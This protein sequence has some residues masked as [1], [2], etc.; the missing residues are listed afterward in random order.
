MIIFGVKRLIEEIELEVGVGKDGDKAY[1]PGTR[2]PYVTIGWSREDGGYLKPE[3]T[4]VIPTSS[5]EA[6]WAVWFILFEEYRRTR[7]GKIHWRRRPELHQLHAWPYGDWG[8]KK[9]I[10]YAVIARLFI[11]ETDEG[12]GKA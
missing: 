12:D 5:E 9:F 3:G 1:C 6:A 7:R 10:G 4:G 11:E 8:P 2:N